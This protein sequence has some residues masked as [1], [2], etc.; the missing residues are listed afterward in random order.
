MPSR[1]LS[2]DFQA[3]LESLDPE[4]LAEIESETTMEDR[5][6]LLALQLACRRKH[7]AFSWL[8]VGSH[9][10]GSLQALVRDPACVRIESIDPRPQEFSDERV[11]SKISYPDNST[12]R[13]LELLGRVDSADTSKIRTHEAT[14]GELDPAEFEAPEV[15]FIDGEHTDAACAADAEFCRRVLRDNGVIAFHDITVIYKAVLAFVMRLDGAG[16]P[17]R[18]AYM[19]DLVFAVEIGEGKVLEDPVIRARERESGMGVLVLLTAND[20]YRAALK[21]RRARALRRLRLLPE[22]EPP[23]R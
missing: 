8:E 16:V 4:L 18:L 7:P 13:M 20:K 17:H 12:E 21:G 22:V 14:T 11:R 3:K 10:G 23:L 19:R 1:E 2:R 9:L 6:S 5:R 15:C